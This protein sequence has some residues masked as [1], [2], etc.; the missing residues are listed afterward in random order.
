M[1]FYGQLNEDLIR[2]IKEKTDKIILD[3]A[4]AHNLNTI[5]FQIRP[6]NDA[7]YP[8]KYNPFVWGNI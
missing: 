7:F 3:N 6:C 2:K 4:Q 1:N 8:S 5:I